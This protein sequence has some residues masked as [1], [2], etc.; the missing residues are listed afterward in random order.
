MGTSLVL[1]V[2]NTIVVWGSSQRRGIVGGS[3]AFDSSRNSHRAR[4][5]PD[6]AGEESSGIEASLKSACRL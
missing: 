3:L 6:P 1:G 4:V 5:P 2:E